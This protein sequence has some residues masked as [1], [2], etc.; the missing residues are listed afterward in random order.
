MKFVILSPRQKWGGAIVLHALCKYLCE[1]G[2]DAKIFYSE[3]YTCGKGLLRY[4][5][6]LLKWLNFVIKDLFFCI[7]SKINKSHDFSGYNDIAVTGCKRRILPF[8]SRKTIVVYP[9]VVFGNPLKAQNVVR[10]FLYYNRFKNSDYAYGRNDL[11]ITYRDEFNDEILNPKNYKLTTSY[12]N[13]K[14]YKQYNFGLRQGTCYVIRKGK[15]RMDLPKSF[16][17]VI[18]DDLSEKEKVRVFN[19]CEYCVSYD[20]QTAYSS[21]A[22]ICGCKSIVVP[23][24]GKDVSDYRHGED[25]RYGVAIGFSNEQ[26]EYAIKTRADLLKHFSSINDSAK[27]DVDRFIKLCSKYF[28]IAK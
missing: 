25:N 16:D 4:I 15:D 11:F 23:E 22:S 24:P 10:W 28:N 1:S 19:E 5:K 2:H 26:M 14:L 18:V 17:G 13:L 20:T 6:F 21:I 8:V 9:D 27:S 3:V 12:F 7:A